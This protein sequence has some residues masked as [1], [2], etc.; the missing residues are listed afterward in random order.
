MVV[1]PA[2]QSS[3]L[4]FDICVSHKRRNIHSVGGDVPVDS[5]APVVTSSISRSNPL[6]QSSGG[7]HRDR[8]CVCAFI[9]VS[10]C[11]CM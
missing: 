11:A 3:N 10:V 8:V 7:A 2:H 4:R 6:A 5:E 1:S 9:E